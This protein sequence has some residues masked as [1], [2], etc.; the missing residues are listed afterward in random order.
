MQSAAAHPA[1]PLELGGHR[2]V[3]RGA[4]RQGLL[5]KLPLPPGPQPELLA[6]PA[7]RARPE[8][9]GRGEDP[10]AGDERPARP[11]PLPAPEVDRDPRLHPLHARRAGAEGPPAPARDRSEEGRH[12]PRRQ[13]LAPA[14]AQFR[15]PL[16]RR[17]LLPSRSAGV[18]GPLDD[19]GDRALCVPG[20]EEG[21]TD[22]LSDARLVQF[23]G[24]STAPEPTNVVHLAEFQSKNELVARPDL[25]TGPVFKTGGGR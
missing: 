11:D 8:R 7:R 19:P 4:R 2:E 13:G 18:D 16:R 14:A 17:R 10:P 3:P 24:T 6:P 25:V 22:K 23:Y 12:L 20:A 5:R 1:R 9:L 21:A 15:E